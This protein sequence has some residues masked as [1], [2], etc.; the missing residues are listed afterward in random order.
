MSPHTS[1]ATVLACSFWLRCCSL[2]EINTGKNLG[3]HLLRGFS[4]ESLP[5]P[6]GP[7]VIFPSFLWVT[8][9][10]K[11]L[12]LSTHLNL[13]FDLCLLSCTFHYFTLN[14]SPSVSFSKFIVYLINR[15]RGLQNQLGRGAPDSGLSV[16]VWAAEV[17]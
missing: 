15:R 10:E 14:S 17:N 4:G 6:H 7:K 11:F 16:R 2:M 12:A 5:P 9:S 8:V 13:L 3:R 1:R